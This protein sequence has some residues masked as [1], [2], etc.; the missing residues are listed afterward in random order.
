MKA[1]RGMAW[2]GECL[3]LAS[4]KEDTMLVTT[5][6]G[7]ESKHLGWKYNGN[8]DW[9]FKGRTRVYVEHIGELSP[10]VNHEDQGPTIVGPPSSE[11]PAPKKKKRGQT[12]QP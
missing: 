8:V 10:A 6:S 9:T 4:A 7:G 2:D 1:P 5:V 12:K 11:V 3:Y